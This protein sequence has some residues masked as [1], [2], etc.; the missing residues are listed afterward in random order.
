M[1]RSRVCGLKTRSSKGIWQLGQ[2]WAP[3]QTEPE[4]EAFLL[5]LK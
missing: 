2:L 4:D 1:L 3:D 5:Q